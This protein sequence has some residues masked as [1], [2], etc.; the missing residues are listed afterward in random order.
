MVKE[1]HPQAV[2]EATATILP[3][4]I[5]AFKVILNMS[6]QHEV[7]ERPSWDGLVIRIEIFKVLAS[8]I[9]HLHYTHHC[10]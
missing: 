3:V 6:P 2:K 10:F 4:W 9:R 1:Q 8:Y 7:Q 5:D